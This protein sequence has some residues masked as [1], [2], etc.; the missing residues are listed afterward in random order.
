V[1]RSAPPA[2][3]ARPLNASRLSEAP[4]LSEL[5]RYS[6]PELRAISSGARDRLSHVSRSLLVVVALLYVAQQPVLVWLSPG[7]W[8]PLSVRIGIAALGMVAALLSLRPRWERHLLRMVHG[9]A[10]LVTAHC[11]A[12]AALNHLP[13]GYLTAVFVLL[14]AG[15]LLF[16]TMESMLLYGS[17]TV[18]LALVAAA[19]AQAPASSRVSLVLGV[20]TVQTVLAISAY[21]R[22]I[23]QRALLGEFKESE[24]R[25]RSLA[26][27]APVGIYRCD[28]LGKC[29]F[30]NQEWCELAGMRAEEAMGQGW[31]AAIHPD[32][33]ERCS[34]LWHEASVLGRDWEAEFRFL[35]R[36]GTVRWAYSRAT[37]VGGELGTARERVGMTIDITERKLAEASMQRTKKLGEAATRA[38]SDFSSKISHER[39]R[40]TA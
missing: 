8:D 1:S 26:M 37:V 24:R 31:A 33:R 36:D 7:A 15:G 25:F 9:L 2:A 40:R 30:A 21:G 32:D 13:P 34:K 35:H 23:A 39:D 10:A 4:R 5:P 11:F 19:F 6:L 12:V 14:A 20:L 16:F 17:F 18:A 28:L 22:V 38:T 3:P 27:G 29:T